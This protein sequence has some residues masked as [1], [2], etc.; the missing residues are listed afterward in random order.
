GIGGVDAD[1]LTK[2]IEEQIETALDTADLV[3]FVVDARSGIVSLDDDVA[4]RL[5][6]ADKPVIL[7]VNK[8]DDERLDIQAEEFYKLGRGRMIK[9]STMQ[10]RGKRELLDAIH[11]K[12]PPFVMFEPPPEEPLLRVAIV[13][14]R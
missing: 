3:L 14:R 10:N 1:N 9:V 11:A 7:V 8:T 13:G 4:K 5:G 6:Y 12:L 2:Q